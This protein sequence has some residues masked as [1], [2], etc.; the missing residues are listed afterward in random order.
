MEA[1][2]YAYRN[3]E[4]P[5]ENM[6]VSL[7]RKSLPAIKHAR[8]GTIFFMY[9]MEINLTATDIIHKETVM[10]KYKL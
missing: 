5:D 7:R 3:P 10:L 6:S 9:K 4:E 8:A 2:I 1:A